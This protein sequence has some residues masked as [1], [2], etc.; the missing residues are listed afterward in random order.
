M[1]IKPIIEEFLEKAVYKLATMTVEIDQRYDAG[2]SLY[3]KLKYGRRELQEF[4]NILN[5]VTEID[6][7]D[8]NWLYPAGWTDEQ[9]LTEIDYLSN[10]YFMSGIPPIQRG[11]CINNIKYIYGVNEFKLLTDTPNGY[12][13]HGGNIV[14]V[15]FD[16]TGLEFSPPTIIIRPDIF[17]ATAGQT[18]FVIP[19]SSNKEIFQMHTLSVGGVLQSKEDYAVVSTNVQRDTIELV[20]PANAGDKI[21]IEYFRNPTVIED[22][23]TFVSLTDTPTDYLGKGGYAV[24]VKSNETGLEFVPVNPLDTFLELTDT[25]ADYT[26]KEG[27]AVY[28]NGNGTGLEFA[29]PTS[30][31]RP[32]VFIAAA[33]QQNFIM[34]NAEENEIFEILLVSVGGAVQAKDNYTIE[35]TNVA[36]DTIHLV[37]PANEDDEVIVEYFKKTI[38]IIT[39]A[40]FLGLVDTPVSYLGEAGKV[41]AV[42][43]D[44]SGLEFIDVTASVI[45]WGDIIGTLSNQT[46]LQTALNNKRFGQS[47]HKIGTLVIGDYLFIGELKIDSAATILGAVNSAYYEPG[48]MLNVFHVHN[49]V[50]YEFAIA[51][52]GLATGI[53]FDKLIFTQ[54]TNGASIFIYLRISEVYVSDDTYAINLTAAFS[55]ST[56]I[57]GILLGGEVVPSIGTIDTEVDIL[58]KD[59]RATNVAPS[60]SNFRELTDTPG[61]YAGHAGRHVAVNDTEDGLEFA[62]DVEI[63]SIEVN[64]RFD[65]DVTATDPTSGRIKVNNVDY[66][67]ATELYI[68]EIDRNGDERH[69]MLSA[70]DAGDVI[71]FRDNNSSDKYF[72]AVV[73]GFGVDNGD[74]WTIPI[75]VK[76]KGITDFNNGERGKFGVIYLGVKHFIGLHDTPSDYSGNAG[77]TPSVTAAE[78]GLEFVDVIKPEIGGTT[79]VANTIWTGTQAEYDAL[80]TYVDTTLYFIV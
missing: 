70:L 74:W 40:T 13:G 53:Q 44:E 45:S 8:S 34:P 15:K 59:F 76:K 72:T 54:E 41:A 66:L 43:G 36:K 55:N 52:Y 75:E 5:E 11:E 46:D 71:V 1:D 14:R 26:G 3:I 24:I 51:H 69:G 35:S 65:V 10:K 28:V 60:I 2:D 23:T 50:K 78:D 33:G 31:I 42:K 16:G 29:S 48:F 79:S 30:I 67:L 4:C 9:I 17:I 64:Y 7:P 20:T 19:S 47:S 22:T 12:T 27:L 6:T 80:G 49:S 56:A 73:L 21:V 32:D 38:N 63:G 61:S 18:H 68:H 62:D 58:A 57:G 25:P 39:T 37:D 77:K